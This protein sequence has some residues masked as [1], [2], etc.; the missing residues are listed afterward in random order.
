VGWEGGGGAPLRSP[1]RPKTSFCFGPKVKVIF[2][3]SPCT[4]FPKVSQTAN[5][6]ASVVLNHHP[7]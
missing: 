4:A 2:W 3:G 1:S 6:Y 7:V 5:E